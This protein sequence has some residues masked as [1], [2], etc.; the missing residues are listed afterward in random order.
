MKK[1]TV[2]KKIVFVVFVLIATTILSIN[3]QPVD[4]GGGPGGGDPPVGGTGVPLDG[5]ALSL[6]IAGVIYGV[7]SLRKKRHR[8][9]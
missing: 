4:P 7:K 2:I 6:L 3:A 1:N 8:N 9:I 5:G